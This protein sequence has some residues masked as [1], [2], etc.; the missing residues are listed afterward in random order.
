[1]EAINSLRTLQHQKVEYSVVG[2]VARLRDGRPWYRG[3]IA[4]FGKRFTSSGNCPER[5]LS[6]QSLLFS[7]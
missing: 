4:G 6:P 2:I 7:G 3:A 1:M 5:L